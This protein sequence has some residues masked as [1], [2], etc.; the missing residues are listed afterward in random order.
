M[1]LFSV[2]TFCM[3]V[4]VAYLLLLA[5]LTLFATT[6]WNANRGD[7]FV[8][9]SQVP[10]WFTQQVTNTATFLSRY[11]ESTSSTS[12]KFRG[13]SYHMAEYPEIDQAEWSHTTDST[14][15]WRSHINPWAQ[16]SSVVS[17]ARGDCTPGYIATTAQRETANTTN[18]RAQVAESQ[19]CNN[20]F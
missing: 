3:C 16:D 14:Q 9:G 11:P 18:T 5:P 17:R 1:K 19:G 12:S 8:G 13:H 2:D 4:R 20:L 15:H 6:G 10:E 7:S